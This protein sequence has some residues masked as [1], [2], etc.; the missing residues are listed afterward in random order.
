MKEEDNGISPST[1][2]H[3]YPIFQNLLKMSGRLC[4]SMG[5]FCRIDAT[6]SK[7]R[8]AV[9]ITGDASP[10]ASSRTRPQGSMIMA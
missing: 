8:S 9:M 1:S 4:F 10:P 7:S 5:I 3:I 2:I 6:I